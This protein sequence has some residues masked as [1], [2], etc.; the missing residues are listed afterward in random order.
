MKF[1]GIYLLAPLGL[2]SLSCQTAVAADKFDPVSSSFRM[3]WGLVVVLAIIFVLY[4]VL[5]KKVSGLQSNDRGAIK[6]IE[7]KHIMPKKSLMLVEIRG[8]EFVVGAG[9]DAIHSIVPLSQSNTF[10]QILERSEEKI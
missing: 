10:S 8:K 4:A 9:N 1:L 2:L 7:V 3:L 5:R 6:I